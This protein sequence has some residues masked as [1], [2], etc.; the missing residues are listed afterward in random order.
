MGIQIVDSK[1]LLSK[2]QVKK[3]KV[4]LNEFLSTK[5]VQEEELSKF[6][7]KDILSNI[8]YENE[9]TTT[10]KYNDISFVKKDDIY[11][12]ILSVKKQTVNTNELRKKLH[13]QM[14]SRS[15]L[16]KSSNDTDSQQWKT[17]HLLKK[18]LNVKSIKVPTPTEIKE[19]S[20]VFS[21]LTENMPNSDFK[22][23]IL[24][25]L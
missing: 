2:N 23:Y 3:I 14:K 19:Q 1:T 4:R 15:Y 21:Q 11:Q 12:I 5:D 6:L 24:N 8:Y 13:M 9:D 18:H 10:E 17:Y 25:C 20:N 16:R 7:E 22:T